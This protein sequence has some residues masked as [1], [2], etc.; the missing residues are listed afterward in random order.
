MAELKTDMDLDPAARFPDDAPD[1]GDGTLNREI[2][3]RFNYAYKYHKDWVET[4]KEDYAFTLGEQWSEDEKAAL[5]DQK[6]P[7][8]V[9]NRIR[10][11][12]NVVAG[13]HRENSSRLKVSPEGQEDKIFTE[14]FD[15]AFLFCDK[16][17]KFTYKQ[18]YQFDD[19]CACGKGWLEAVLG[20]DRDP[21]FGEIRWLHLKPWQIYVDPDSVEYDI[22]EDAGYVFKV[23][24]Y[25]KAKLIEL[26][27]KKE[28][29]IKGFTVDND[30]AVDNVSVLGEEDDYGNRPG[31]RS[32]E[33]TRIA[34]PEFDMDMPLTVKEYWRKKMVVK[35]FIVQD[36]EAIKF[37]TREEAER[38]AASLQPKSS[39][40]PQLPGMPPVLQIPDRNWKAPKV[41]DRKVPE[42]WVAIRVC[43]HILLD[44]K[45]PF[46]PYTTMY[47]FFRF[48]ADWSPSA[49]TEELKAMGVTRPLK[50][51]Q[52]EKNKAKS[53][54]L[55]ILNTSAH[56]GWKGD[57]NALSEPGWQELKK[58]GSSPG[59]VLRQTPGTKLEQIQPVMPAQG[60]LL[61]EQSADEEFKQISNINPDLL[62]IADKTTSGKAIG[63][64]IRQAVTALVR[65]FHN[66]RYTKEVMGK[67]LVGIM[68]LLFSARKL[69]KVIGT[70]YMRINQLDEGKLAAYLQMIKDAK[71]DLVVAEADN[72]SSIRSEIFGQ[73]IELAKTPAGQYLPPELLVDYM[74]IENSKEVKDA[75][76]QT[77]QAAIAAQQAELAAKTVVAGHSGAPAQ[78]PQPAIPQLPGR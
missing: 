10:P 15:R 49:E 77:R 18:G 38:Y 5:E 2:S 72:T 55:H 40:A 70:Q 60:H 20:Y 31:G 3:Q 24:T 48:I 57:E 78:T 61:R 13:Y 32:V 66:Y 29:A 35:Y 28:K 33:G 43:G 52:R 12:I 36:G 58:L 63:L 69:G 45:S 17:G 46:E 68:P 14:V 74:E 67:F 16:V 51:P 47:P 54:Y 1:T 21:I 56:S 59:V 73:L 50:D 71:Y 26:F 30:T 27:P 9:F 7:A 22:N 4:A 75:I 44:A 42:M 37:E 34:E 11:L 6:R 25:T 64:R 19:G 8:L 62:G 76:A 65:I 39:G 41:F 23:C 53:Q